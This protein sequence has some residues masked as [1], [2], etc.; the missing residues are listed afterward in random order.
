LMRLSGTFILMR[1]SETFGRLMVFWRYSFNWHYI[2]I[3]CP[4]LI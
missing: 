3:I 4:S 1:L 2:I